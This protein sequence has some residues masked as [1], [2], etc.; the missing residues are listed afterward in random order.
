VH[1]DASILVS[2]LGAGASTT[3]AF[4]PERGAYVYL[5]AGGVS[6]NG[7]EELTT[8]DAATVRDED[9]LTVSAGEPSELIMVDVRPAS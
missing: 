4:A 9:T 2:S 8:G 1:G 5:I 6:L 3:Y 7:A